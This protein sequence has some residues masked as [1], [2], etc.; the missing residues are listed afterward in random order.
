MSMVQNATGNAVFT[1]RIEDEFLILLSNVDDFLVVSSTKAIY[2]KVKK[3]LSSMFDITTQEGHIINFLNLQII[4]I[5][6]D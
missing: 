3:K 5:S 4:A 6:L 1:F 2:D